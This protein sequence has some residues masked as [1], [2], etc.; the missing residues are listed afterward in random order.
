M[1]MKDSIINEKLQWNTDMEKKLNR[2]PIVM[3]SNQ[4]IKGTDFHYHPGLE[5]HI[6]HDGA[7][8]M[9]V[10]KQILLQNPRSVLVFRGM[11]PHQMIS[12]SSYKRTVISVNF[13]GDD[14]HTLPSLHRLI[15]FGWIPEDSCLNFSLTPKQFQQ[16]EEMCRMLRHELTVREV[17]W[18]RMAL[19][20]TLEITVFLERSLGE[21]Q[22]ATLSPQSNGK[23]TDLVQICSDYV[24]QGLGE[25]LSLKAVSKRFAV[26]EEYLT[27]SFTKEMGISFYQYVLLQRVAEGKRLLR[28]APDVSITDIAYMIGF[29]SS[30]HLSKHFKTLTGETPSAYRQKI[31][32]PQNGQ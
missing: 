3:H 32:E 31:F 12:K 2:F 9:V 10:G 16:L 22:T 18:E 26:S 27:R 7:G 30:S 19:S 28:E 8:T 21:T 14:S 13:G 17:G 1:D 29:P 24:C 25:D 20:H 6:T 11:V 4:W 5:I 15:D 23:V